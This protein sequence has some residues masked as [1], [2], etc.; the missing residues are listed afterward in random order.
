M[1]KITSSPLGLDGTF[2]WKDPDDIL[3]KLT[4]QYFVWWD[5]P[6]DKEYLQSATALFST[7][8][9]KWTINGEEVNVV[10]WADPY[11]QPET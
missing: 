11:L 6:S 3:P 7:S 9:S 5:D 1:A 8:E 4:K 10:A 2:W